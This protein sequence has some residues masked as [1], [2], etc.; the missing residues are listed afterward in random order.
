MFVQ[1]FSDN[2]DSSIL[3]RTLKTIEINLVNICNRKCSFCP[4][5]KDFF[6]KDYISL[7]TLEKVA[8]NISKSGYANQITLSGFGEPILHKNF[9][10]CLSILRKKLPDNK[11]RI[12]TNGDFLKEDI[13][14]AIKNFDIEVRVSKYDNEFPNLKFLNKYEIDFEIR[15]YY[16]YYDKSFFNNRSYGD[17]KYKGAC[18][19]P[20]YKLFVETDGSI[21][22]CS[23]N[24]FSNS[25]PFNL[26]D[27]DLKNIWFKLIKNFRNK[28]SICRSGNDY[29]KNCSVNGRLHG[30]KELNI[31]RDFNYA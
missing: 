15:D 14:I 12:H 24:W 30:F 6:R 16:K 1:K 28:A 8:R 25:L 3:N 31:L 19:I 7:N 27:N 29:C 23:H 5:S 20:S 21:R 2:K 4:Q 9:K 17:L 22:P 18:Y 13:V 10:E 26:I 11:I